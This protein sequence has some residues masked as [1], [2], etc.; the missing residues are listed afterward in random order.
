MNEDPRFRTNTDRLRNRAAV[1]EAVGAWFAQKTQAEALA[2]MREAGV[3]V[4]P[5]YDI[6]GALADPH[7][8]EREI[9]VETQDRSWERCRCITSC[10]GFPDPGA[11]RRPAPTLGQH[12]DEVLRAAGL[13]DEAIAQLRAE[14]GCL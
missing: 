6:E 13:N 7:F 10:R 11:W 9:F 1:D 4:G 5:V 2:H 3:T 8:Q 14:G 12:T